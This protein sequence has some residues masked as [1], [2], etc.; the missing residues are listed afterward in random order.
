MLNFIAMKRRRFMQAI[1][2]APAAGPLL[3]QSRSQ[4]PSEGPVV[5]QVPVE[6]QVAPALKTTF[7]EAAAT[8]EP[9]FF[10]PEQFATLRRLSDLFVPALNGNPGALAAGAPEFLDF[11]TSV[12]AASRQELYRNGLNDLNA[13]ARSKFKKPFAELSNNEADQI[14]KPLFKPRGPLQAFLELGPFA[15]RALQ[16]IRTVTFNS[17]A[18]A[19]NAA[20]AGQRIPAPLYWQK[21]DPTVLK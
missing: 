1:A 2:V 10:S 15:N 13:Q 6:G 19:E 11:Y 18:Y 21:V 3:A 16:D 5:G 12:S 9:K 7:S 14:L 4:R 8:P 20:A 17:P